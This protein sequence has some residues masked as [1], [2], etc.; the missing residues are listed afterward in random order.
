[1]AARMWLPTN[2]AFALRGSDRQMDLLPGAT[3]DLKKVR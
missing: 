2:L 3:F 1:M